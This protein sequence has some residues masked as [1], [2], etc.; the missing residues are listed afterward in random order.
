[1]YSFDSFLVSTQDQ[2]SKRNNSFRKGKKK[3][4]Q[5]CELSKII[6]LKFIF[7]LFLTPLLVFQTPQS[8]DHHLSNCLS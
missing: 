3:I 6:N 1:M 2:F 8:N 7:F 5:C 4:Y